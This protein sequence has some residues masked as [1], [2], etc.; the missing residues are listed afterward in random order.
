MLE[1]QLEQRLVQSTKL[2]TGISLITEKLKSYQDLVVLLIK[3]NAS[4]L[5]RSKDK[6]EHK[7]T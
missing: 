4:Y 7:H 2:G 6:S 1:Q 3:P 5:K